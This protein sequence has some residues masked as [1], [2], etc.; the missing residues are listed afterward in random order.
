[1]ISRFPYRVPIIIEPKCKKAPPI[2][3]RKYMAPRELTMAQM[4]FV[5]R[6]RLNMRSE[7]ALFFFLNNN[8]MV[9]PADPLGSI[10][11]TNKDE[12]NFLYIYYSLENTFGNATLDPNAKLGECV[13]E[14]RGR[15]LEL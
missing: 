5:V 9:P 4:M 15:R 10:Y 7:Q 11:D 12:D 14:C 3:K 6:K 1:M 8:T 13:T 2:D